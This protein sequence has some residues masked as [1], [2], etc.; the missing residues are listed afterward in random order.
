MHKILG[1]IILLLTMVF[2][3]CDNEDVSPK[4]EYRVINNSDK[5]ATIT[6]LK[7]EGVTIEEFVLNAEDIIVVW[8]FRDTPL[9]DSRGIFYEVY[10]GDK[11]AYG[12]D[13]RPLDMASPFP[14]REVN[15]KKV[16]YGSCTTYSLF[17]WCGDELCENQC[18]NQ[19][20]ESRKEDDRSNACPDDNKFCHSHD[21]MD[22]SQASSY[23]MGWYDGEAYCKDIGGRLPT[24]SELRTLIQNCP[25]TEYP[26]PEGQDP[27]CDAVEDENN[28]AFVFDQSA[29]NPDCEGDLNVF[30]Y[31]CSF[32]SSSMAANGRNVA[33]SFKSGAVKAGIFEWS[34]RVICVKKQEENL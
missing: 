33:V 7:A 4:I 34:H 9:F 8:Q 20:N 12:C 5:I 21:G 30:G 27:W 17:I 15:H 10:L 29:C 24:I 32:G 2:I 1:V 14:G 23:Y 6:I 3:G 22:W 26:K 11:F 28:E 31:T 25:Q 16:K 19:Y 13:K 18:Y